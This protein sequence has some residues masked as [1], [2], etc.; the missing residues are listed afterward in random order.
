MTIAVGGVNKDREI[1]DRFTTITGFNNKHLTIIN[2]HRLIISLLLLF[3]ETTAGHK[4]MTSM[5][6]KT[7][8]AHIEIETVPSREEMAMIEKRMKIV[9]LMIEEGRT[10]TIANRVMIESV[11]S[12]M[13]VVLMMIEE[14]TTKEDRRM[15]V[16]S[17]TMNE[18]NQTIEN[19]IEE[20]I[21][22]NPLKTS[23]EI[24]SLN[25]VIK[26][27]SVKQAMTR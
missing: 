17:K 20:R 22:T 8:D 3:L 24:A 26:L 5:I 19:L 13:N 14:A 25:V 1:E 15:I 6:T 10:M 12:K 23:D 18:A 27:K 4:M 2:Y 11:R 7:S 16:R 9:D 21:T